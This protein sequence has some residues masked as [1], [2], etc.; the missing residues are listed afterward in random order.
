MNGGWKANGTLFEMAVSEGD[1]GIFFQTRTYNVL[2]FLA[3]G[4]EHSQGPPLR[5]ALIQIL[6]G[7]GKSCNG[8][9]EHD[10]IRLYWFSFCDLRLSLDLQK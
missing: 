7:K 9:H 6:N 8:N 5:P 10:Y 2:K 4:R 1:S 3:N